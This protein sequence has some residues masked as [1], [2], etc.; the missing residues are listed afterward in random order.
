MT[1][2][3]LSYIIAII[4]VAV[5]L[6]GFITDSLDNK[7]TKNS[8]SPRKAT[9]TAAVEAPLNW[10]I[11]S[12][13]RFDFKIAYPPKA[14][15]K[16][17]GP[18]N[19]HIKFTYLGNNN[20]TGEITDGF[21]LTISLYKLASS[22]DLQTF[23]KKQ[24]QKP[25]TEIQANPLIQTTL[26]S[27]P[28]YSYQTRSL[29]TITHIVTRHTDNRAFVA[30]FNIADPHNEN[31]QKI[32]KSM[33]NSLILADIPGSGMLPADK[34]AKTIE[35]ALFS[36]SPGQSS[37]H[38]T[39][40]GQITRIQRSITPADAPLTAALQ[41]LF[42]LNRSTVQKFYNPLAKAK[43]TLSFQRATV[44]SSGVARIYMTGR[45]PSTLD[46]CAQQQIYTQIKQT[47][48]QFPNIETVRLY[49]DGTYIKAPSDL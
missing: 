12:H 27:Q 31:Y 21:T 35:L 2:R 24:L 28:A 13:A 3:R 44:D 39:G 49:R 43:K 23:A 6:S 25:P 15:V 34:N 26:A 45:L 1:T 19:R 40:C 4:V 18:K 38:A 29:G 46:T 32:V 5:I 9:S 30:S 11:Y 22:T 47:A 7:P 42:S 36:N 20:A 17:E 48:L 10:S 14:R 16:A 41:I 8:H 37:D 33:L